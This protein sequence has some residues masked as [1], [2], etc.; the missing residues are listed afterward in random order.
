MTH[1]LTI[2]FNAANPTVLAWL[3]KIQAQSAHPQYQGD[4]EVGYPT[5]VATPP[6]R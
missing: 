2:R 1:E 4:V 6:D 3:Q 5:P